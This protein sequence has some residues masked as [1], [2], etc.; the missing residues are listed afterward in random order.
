[1]GDGLVL[2]QGTH[3]ELLRDESGA[4]S[5]LVA[6]QKLREQRDE[7]S[8]DTGS[9]TSVGDEAEV[10][11]KKVR[12]EIPLGRK[13]TSRSLASEIIERKKAEQ[14]E[15]EDEDHSL[16]Y[17]FKRFALINRDGWRNYMIGTVAACSKCFT[18]YLAAYS[19]DELASSDWCCVPS[20][21]RCVCQ[22]YQCVLGS[23]RS[24]ATSRRRSRC[25]LALP[26]CRRILLL[27]R[28]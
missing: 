12:E 25:P 16:P 5:R 7:D 19:W 20:V 2:E 9:A 8:S 11:A 13:S 18:L 14:Q 28:S 17:I 1:M 26:H 21:W 6:A 10:M 22:G 3:S 4:Y 15:K 27:S 24:P 23:R